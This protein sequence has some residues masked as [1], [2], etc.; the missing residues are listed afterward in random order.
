MSFVYGKGARLQQL[1]TGEVGLWHLCKGGGEAAH[2]L[3]IYLC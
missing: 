2:G 1:C 3:Y